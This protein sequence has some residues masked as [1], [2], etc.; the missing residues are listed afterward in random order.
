M[1]SSP[2]KFV[3]VRPQHDEAAL[4][5]LA[6]TMRQRGQTA[7]SVR[8]SK[9]KGVRSLAFLKDFQLEQLHVEQ[10]KAGLATVAKV[11]GLRELRLFRMRALDLGFLAD[12]PALERLILNGVQLK[13]FPPGELPALKQL[14][15]WNCGD[16][17]EFDFLERLPGLE[18]LVVVGAAEATALPSLAAST[19]LHSVSLTDFPH[20]TT[21]VGL[22]AAPALRMLVVQD[23]PVLPPEA[24]S[25]ALE[26]PCLEYIYPAID[27]VADSP[28]L[29][30][31]VDLLAPRFGADLMDQSW[32]PP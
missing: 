4:A 6:E 9:L 31:A 14:T 13:A 20:L 30:A 17:G 8:K 1:P 29:Q 27:T 28:R 21:L 24:L 15:L 25:F 32:P 23:T 5:A 22:A 3:N 16:L 18:A 12:M 11:E 19:S 10:V 2:V 26:H 7:L